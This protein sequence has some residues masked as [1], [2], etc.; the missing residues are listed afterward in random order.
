MVVLGEG[1]AVVTPGQPTFTDV[2]PADWHFSYIETAVGHGIVS[3]YPDG[4]FKP[5][6][7]V[8]RGQLSKVIVLGRLWA[9][10]DPA[11]PSF[12]DVPPASTFYRYVE[13]AK[14][15]SVVSGYGDGTF[16]PNVE[17]TRG[18]LAKMLYVALTQDPGGPGPGTAP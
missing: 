9:L 14:A 4:T 6:N 17:A 12:S 8:T 10:L 3:G 7:W 15:H 2:G 5:N 13:T 16:R 11:L 1:W 18:Q